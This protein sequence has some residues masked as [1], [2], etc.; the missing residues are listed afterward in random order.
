MENDKQ[1]IIVYR[2]REENIISIENSKKDK[3]SFSIKN[4]I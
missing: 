3:D 4:E 1:I 2:D